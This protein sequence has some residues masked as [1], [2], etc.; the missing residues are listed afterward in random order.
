MHAHWFKC[1]GSQDTLCGEL[2]IVQDA[3]DAHTQTAVRSP[4]AD[5]EDRAG[6]SFAQLLG[7][8]WLWTV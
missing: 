2:V 8:L 6:G 7:L 4:G 5:R 3:S 1:Y